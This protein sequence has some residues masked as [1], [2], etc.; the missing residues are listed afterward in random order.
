MATLG[1]GRVKGDH[2][3]VKSRH[4]VQFEMESRRVVYFGPVIRPPQ[5]VGDP[6]VYLCGG[7]RANGGIT[8]QRKEGAA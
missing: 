4:R 2:L 5:N 3:A 7:A 8:A 1:G 6:H